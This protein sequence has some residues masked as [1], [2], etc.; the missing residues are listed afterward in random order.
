MALDFAKNNDV[1]NSQWEQENEAAEQ[2]RQIHWEKIC[3]QKLKVQDLRDKIEACDAT[4]QSIED[5]LYSES[6]TT[7]ARVRLESQQSKE[8]KCRR[9][10]NKL[11]IEAES[12]P[13]AVYQPLPEDKD[14]ALT[15]L[16]FIYMPDEFRVLSSLSFAAQHMLAPRSSVV[17]TAMNGGKCE[18]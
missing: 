7:E 6:V 3:A 15:V 16:F 5:Q 12:P 8:K 18:P 11:L 2:K 14:K 13:H 17:F 1:L 10:L 4:L 9:A